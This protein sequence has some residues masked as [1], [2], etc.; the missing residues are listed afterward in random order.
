MREQMTPQVSLA[1]NYILNSILTFKFAPNTFVSDNQVAKEL[2]IS[3][4]PV[5]EAIW[6]LVTDGLIKSSPEG[7][8]IVAPI[9]MSDIADIF[10]IRSA[11]ENEAIRI[12][13]SQK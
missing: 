5:R 2:G 10:H 4:A 11:L 6:K 7:K 3:R 13:A 9:N 12:I 8:M 1:Y